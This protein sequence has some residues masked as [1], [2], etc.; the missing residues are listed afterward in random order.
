MVPPEP[1]VLDP[2]SNLDA[3]PAGAAVYLIWPKG[4]EPYLGRTN[5][6]RRRLIR[7]FQKWN[8]IETAE[9]IEYWLTPSKIE[10]WLISYSLARQ[11]F[12]ET[13][14]RV[15]KLPKP[16]YVQLLLANAYPRTRI[17]TRLSG[18]QSVFYGPFPSRSAADQFEAQF[19]E[20][21]QIR[22]CQDDLVPSPEHP[23]CIYG[24]MRMC[25][26]PCQEAVS[27]Q[28]YASEA[29]RVRDFLSTR[30]THLIESAATARDRCSDELNFEEA[31]RQHARVSRIESIVKLSGDLARDITRLHGVAVTPAS[32]PQQ[33]MLWFLRAGCWTG[34]HALSIAPGIP[35]PLDKRL[36]AIVET[37]AEPKPTL[38]MRQ[39][40][41]AL[42]VKWYFSSWR[43]GEWLLIEDWNQIPYRRL[44]N[45]ISRVASA[46]SAQLTLPGI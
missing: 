45:A 28:E 41:L 22:R 29:E 25:L 37:I 26:R 32:D 1:L 20:L 24:E 38:S 30:G 14:P 2:R 10:Q 34:S 33:V 11:W 27:A 8:L 18:S 12:P 42:L 36:R 35:E 5:I 21:F 13:Y 43:D 31:Q 15:L 9:R 6:L 3:L 17:G 4:G 39:D 40:H 44:V 23:G 19:L 7:L 16:P 46:K